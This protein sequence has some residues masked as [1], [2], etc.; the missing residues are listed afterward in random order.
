MYHDIH[1]DGWWLEH[2]FYPFVH[3]LQKQLQ[4]RSGVTGNKDWLLL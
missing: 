2:T 4:A 1:V 3:K